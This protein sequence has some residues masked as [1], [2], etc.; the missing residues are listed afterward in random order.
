MTITEAEQRQALRDRTIGITAACAFCG[1]L[2]T[3][4]DIRITPDRLRGAGEHVW[5]VCDEC[6]PSAANGNLSAVVARDLLGLDPDDPVL[7]TVTVESFDDLSSS[8]PDR[9]NPAAWAHVDVDDLAEQ[10]AQ[11]RVDV[12][13]RKGGPCGFCGVALT[14]PGT[15]WKGNTCGSCLDRFGGVP[16]PMSGGN[17]DRAA[18]I[19]IGLEGHGRIMQPHGLGAQLGVVWWSETDRKVPNRTPFAHLDIAGMRTEAKRLV[20]ESR[21]FVPP[22]WWHPDNLGTVTW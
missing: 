12:E 13:R 17:R 22:K 9:P 8:H 19:I 10:V 4:T 11:A 15:S 18:A 14:A 2:A 1:A 20:V 21:Y 6:G 16:L 7:R 5:V 3:S